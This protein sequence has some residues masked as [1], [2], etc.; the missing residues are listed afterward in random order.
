[1]EA[2]LAQV[3]GRDGRLETRA[4]L[5]L[6]RLGLMSSDRALLEEHISNLRDHREELEPALQR[7]LMELEAA[8]AATRGD[9]AAQQAALEGARRR[10][11]E[12]IDAVERAR[13][14][15]RRLEG[16]KPEIERARVLAEQ[17]AR[18]GAQ[19]G[20]VRSLMRK[21]LDHQRRSDDATLVL[22][23][24]IAEWI[25]ASGRTGVEAREPQVDPR[26]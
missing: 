7:E 1:L 2:A 16:V 15:V 23:L 24:A 11:D 13:A 14:A 20:E 18:A 12:A 17:A 10:L 25:A 3:R 21:V 6:A 5:D 22:E 19:S 26:R 9:F 8:E 4:R